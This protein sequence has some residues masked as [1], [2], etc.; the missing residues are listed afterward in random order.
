LTLWTSP[1]QQLNSTQNWGLIMEPG[2]MGPQVKL[3]LRE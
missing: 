1:K 2:H 3:P